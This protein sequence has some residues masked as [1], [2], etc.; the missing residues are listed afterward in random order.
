MENLIFNKWIEISATLTVKLV[1]VEK[2][3]NSGLIT[4]YKKDDINPVKTL[5]VNGRKVID[6]SGK[7]LDFG[8]AYPIATDYGKEMITKQFIKAWSLV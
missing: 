6:K 8:D 5:V 1:F 2:S 7:V 3:N 4:I